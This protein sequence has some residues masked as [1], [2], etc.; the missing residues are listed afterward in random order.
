MG[1][2]PAPLGKSRCRKFPQR[3]TFTFSSPRSN[4]IIQSNVLIDHIDEK[5]S[6]ES[7][8]TPKRPWKWSRDETRYWQYKVKL[9]ILSHTQNKKLVMDSQT[10]GYL[11]V[12]LME[13]PVPNFKRIQRSWKRS[14]KKLNSIYMDSW[15]LRYYI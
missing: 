6:K 8:D 15:E 1:R 3:L 14:N 4:L 12:I 10:C 5:L 13:I 2:L 7:G 9:S 11:D